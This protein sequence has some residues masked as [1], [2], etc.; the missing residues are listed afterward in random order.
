METFSEIILSS[1]INCRVL[2]REK[3]I[4]VSRIVANLVTA[5]VIRVILSAI[6]SDLPLSN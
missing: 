4:K 6:L 2:A 1:Q 5:T 3:A